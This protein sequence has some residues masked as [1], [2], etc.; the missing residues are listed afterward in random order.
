MEVMTHND[1]ALFNFVGIEQEV[2]HGRQDERF[3]LHRATDFT[4]YRF[5]SDLS[6]NKIMWPI[7]SHAALS[8]Q[9]K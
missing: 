9:L 7:V 8:L 1:Q 6:H 3:Q 4:D 2:A 5:N